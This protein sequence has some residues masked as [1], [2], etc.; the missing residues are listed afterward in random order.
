MPGRDLPVPYDLGPDGLCLVVEDVPVMGL[1]IGG[2][3][4]VFRG[5][6]AGVKLAGG[7]PDAHELNRLTRER[8][9]EGRCVSPVERVNGTVQ[10]V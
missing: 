6:L 1:S 4:L 9:A 2:V 5:H 3:H 10:E 7:D 8:V